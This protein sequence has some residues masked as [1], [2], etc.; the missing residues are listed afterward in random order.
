MPTGTLSVAP[1]K[2]SV[3]LAIVRGS[4]TSKFSKNKCLSFA[5]KP[6]E[7]QPSGTCNFSRI[8]IAELNRFNNFA[9]D[10][11]KNLYLQNTQKIYAVNYNVLNFLL[12]Q[13]WVV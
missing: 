3:A 4:N 12:C 13:V 5:L 10:D 7:H 11:L 1:R 8:D 9:N 6:E 2:L